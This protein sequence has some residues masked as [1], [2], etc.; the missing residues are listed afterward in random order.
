MTRQNRRFA[1]IAAAFVLFLTALPLAAEERPSGVV[2]VNS[3][4]AEQLQLL[5]RIGPAIAE[6]IVEFREEHRPFRSKEEL[7]L[8]RGIGEATFELIE[9]YVAVSGETTLSEKVPAPR[10][11]ADGAE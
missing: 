8:V 3:A 2:N 11:S 6:R 9:P 7:L 1:V 4:T 10:R 5:P